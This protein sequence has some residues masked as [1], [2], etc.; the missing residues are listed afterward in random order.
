VIDPVNRDLVGATLRAFSS[1]YG[2][3]DMRPY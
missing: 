3:Q 1:A 2:G